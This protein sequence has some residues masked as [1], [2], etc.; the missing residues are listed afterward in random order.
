MIGHLVHDHAPNAM[1]NF[2]FEVT[3][4]FRRLEKLRRGDR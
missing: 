3:L 1:G 4:G 2:S